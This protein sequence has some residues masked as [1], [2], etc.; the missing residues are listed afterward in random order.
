MLEVTV[1]ELLVALVRP[2]LLAVSEY[3]P[4]VFRTK[5]LNVATPL[6]AATEVEIPDGLETKLTEA[7]DPV[8]K[9]P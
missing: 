3:V 9:F 7:L 5:P 6:T 2:L 1:K 8:T 4:A